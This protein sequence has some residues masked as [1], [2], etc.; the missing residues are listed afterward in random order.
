MHAWLGYWT[1]CIPGIT[2]SSLT[3]P[4]TEK[5]CAKIEHIINPSLVKILGLPDTFPNRMVYG[6]KYFGGIGLLK[7]FAEKGMN[8]TLSLMRH[9]RAQTTL[10]NKIIIALRHYQTQAGISECVPTYTRPLPHMDILWFDTFF[11]HYLVNINGHIELTNAWRLK[12][13]E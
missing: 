5:Q 11:R 13:Q 6:D 3:I 7:L 12:P 10:G 2:Y 8:Q 4:L 1:V 9:I